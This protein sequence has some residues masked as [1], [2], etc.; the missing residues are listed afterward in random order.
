[1][2]LARI[3]I[4]EHIS[5]RDVVS[6]GLS[7]TGITVLVI[8]DSIFNLRL[9]GALLGDMLILGA[10]VIAAFYTILVRDLGQTHSSLV[11]TSF[12]TFFG[13]LF[14]APFFFLEFRRVPW[15]TIGLRPTLAV[16]YLS[17]FA[18][19]LAFL[20]YN[21]ALT[22]IP[23]SRVAVFINGIPVVTTLAAWP[24]LNE[25]LGPVQLLGGGLVLLAVYLANMKTSVRELI[26]RVQG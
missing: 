12:Q 13:T 21:H 1:M 16:I 26:T 2:I 11:I 25:R 23:A 8:G 18:T 24:L 4:G 22:R 19:T 17:I 14:Y 7:F 6:I 15:G 10:V 20:C 3:F 9:G 5:L